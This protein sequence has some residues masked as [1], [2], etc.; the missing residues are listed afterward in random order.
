[1]TQTPEQ[2]AV[3]L[4]KRER[5]TLRRAN[6]RSLPHTLMHSCGCCLNSRGLLVR[7][8]L[9]NRNDAG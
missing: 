2:I 5:N 6:G 9:E 8:I 1:M 3:G 7:T 4:T